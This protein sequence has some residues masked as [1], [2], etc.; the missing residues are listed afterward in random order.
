MLSALGAPRLTGRISVHPCPLAALP[1]RRSG[2]VVKPER[3][4]L[5]TASAGG[6][7]MALET[8]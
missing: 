8:K 2:S 6:G 5:L 1:R 3:T 4:S 7:T